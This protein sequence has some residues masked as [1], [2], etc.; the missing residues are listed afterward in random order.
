MTALTKLQR[1]QQLAAA[2]ADTA[3][4]MNEVQKGG[5]GGRRLPIGNAMAR[6]IGVIEVGQHYQKV[7]GKP[8]DKPDFMFYLGFAL[9]GK[10]KAVD[11][12]GQ[13]ILENGKPVIDTFEEDGKPAIRWT[14]Y[15]LNLSRNE[16][17]RSY[18]LFKKMNYKGTHK[19]YIGMVGEAFLL[20]CTYELS[21]DQT[22]AYFTMQLNEI[23]PPF[24]ENPETLETEPLAVPEA[25]EDAIKYFIWDNPDQA[26][27]L[28]SF[29]SLFVEGKWDDGS[30]KNRYQNEIM[31][32][33]NFMGSPLHT[34]LV[35][36]GANIEL[37][38]LEA[39]AGASGEDPDGDLP[40]VPAAPPAGIP[41]VP[42]VPNVPDIPDV[43]VAP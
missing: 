41:D 19:Q 15:A 23:K 32:A 5:G 34:A 13:P 12:K 1:A 18:L 40:D 31:S 8:K 7:K 22:K 3:P 25:P 36:S 4:D 38:S 29:H 39:G 27:L 16:K 30:S 21:K 17:A 10:G 42:D 35:A 43:P 28:E 33:V 11:E 2:V 20:P 37:P 24:R 14:P 9:W 6:L 26:D